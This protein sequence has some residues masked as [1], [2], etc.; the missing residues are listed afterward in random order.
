M[1]RTPYL[2]KVEYSNYLQQQILKQIGRLSVS[3][4]FF[5]NA[6]YVPVYLK[7]HVPSTFITLCAMATSKMNDMKAVI[8]RAK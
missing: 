8:R 4:V 5:V 6:L 2:E 1:S 7:K 3:L